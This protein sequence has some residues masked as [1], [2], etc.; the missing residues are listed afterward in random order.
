[1]KRTIANYQIDQ[2]KKA[3]A[4]KEEA[5]SELWRSLGHYD[6]KKLIEQEKI[7]EGSFGCVYRANYDKKRVVVKILQGTK[8]TE[9][10]H[11]GMKTTG[12][13]N[14]EES[15]RMLR[16][17][18]EYEATMLL[19]AETNGVL[20]LI[21]LDI[22]NEVPRMITEYMC[23][24]TLEYEYKLAEAG[25]KESI[26]HPN[27]EHNLIE[28]ANNVTNP[29]LLQMVRIARDVAAAISRI[30]DKGI[31]HLDIAARNILLD[32]KKRP[33]LADFGCAAMEND[34]VEIHDLHKATDDDI[35]IR[36]MKKIDETFDRK[37][38][39]YTHRRPWRWMPH[40]VAV[41][42]PLIDRKVDVYSFGC[43]MFEMAA[44]TV[45]HCTVNDADVAQFKKVKAFNP[46]IPSNLDGRY[47]KIMSNCWEDYDKSPAMSSIAKE[48]VDL[49]SS[50]ATAS[51]SKDIQE[52]SGYWEFQYVKPKEDTI[53]NK[54]NYQSLY[55]SFKPPD[56]IPPVSH[57][58]NITAESGVDNT[59]PLISERINLSFDKVDLSDAPPQIAEYE[60][61]GY[62]KSK[63]S[64]ALYCAY[65]LR[66]HRS[67]ALYMLCIRIED[68]IEQIEMINQCFV[69]LGQLAED[70][71]G[72]TNEDEALD[73]LCWA[74]FAVV[75]EVLNLSMNVA[76]SVR[77]LLISNALSSLGSL[78]SNRTLSEVDI[79]GGNSV[80]GILNLEN[81]ICNLVSF[82]LDNH[83]Q[84]KTIVDTVAQT[85]NSFTGLSQLMINKLHQKGIVAGLLGALQ[86]HEDNVDVSWKLVRALS[87]FPIQQLLNPYAV[88]NDI[89]APASKPSVGKSSPTKSS[90]VGGNKS[91]TTKPSKQ[92]VRIQ[93]VLHDSVFDKLFGIVISCS[94]KLSVEEGPEVDEDYMVLVLKL[95]ETCLNCLFRMCESGV[96]DIDTIN[97]LLHTV[98]LDSITTLVNV[99]RGHSDNFTIQEGAIGLLAHIVNTGF[100]LTIEDNVKSPVHLTPIASGEARI[101]K[102]LELD[103]KLHLLL[104][105]MEKFKVNNHIATGIKSS[106]SEDIKENNNFGANPYHTRSSSRT[107]RT[108]VTLSRMRFTTTTSIVDE[109]VNLQ[110]ATFELDEN[111]E[112]ITAAALQR[113]V[114]IILGIACKRFGKQM[115]DNLLQT[116][117]NEN[118]LSAFNIFS[119]DVALIQFGCHAL[120]WTSRRHTKHQHMLG[121]LFIFRH[122]MSVLQKHRTMWRVVEAV[123]SALLGLMDPADDVSVLSKS[124]ID[125]IYWHMKISPEKGFSTMEE[126]QTFNQECSKELKQQKE[127]FIGY[128]IAQQLTAPAIISLHNDK[129]MIFNFL[130]LFALL[131]AYLQTQED[132]QDLTSQFLRLICCI[133]FWLPEYAK[134]WVDDDIIFVNLSVLGPE[135][136]KMFLEK[137]IIQAITEV[138]KPD[139]PSGAKSK[140]LGEKAD[141]FNKEE[142]NKDLNAIDKFSK[143]LSLSEY[144]F[145]ALEVSRNVIEYP[146][147]LASGLAVITSMFRFTLSDADLVIGNE[148]RDYRNRKSDATKFRDQIRS[149]GIVN[150]CLEA[151]VRQIDHPILIRHSLWIFTMLIS[152]ATDVLN[153]KRRQDQIDSKAIASDLSIHYVPEWAITVAEK[154][155]R[156]YSLQI[157]SFHLLCWMEI[158]GFLKTTFISSLESLRKSAQR[159]LDAPI[160]SYK[161][162]DEEGYDAYLLGQSNKFFGDLHDVSRKMLRHIDHFF[163]RSVG[164]DD[165]F[166]SSHINEKSAQEIKSEDPTTLEFNEDEARDKLMIDTMG[167]SPQFASQ[168]P[169]D[170]EKWSHA[171]TFI[172]FRDIF[173]E[174]DE[175]QQEYREKFRKGSIKGSD[176][177][178]MTEG[179]LISQIGIQLANL[180]SRF[181]EKFKL[182]KVYQ[183]KQLADGVYF[184][185]ERQYA[186]AIRGKSSYDFPLSMSEW[187]PVDVLALLKVPD[188]AVQLDKFL[189]PLALTGID[190]TTLLKIAKESTK[191][192]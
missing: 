10:N 146:N 82:A 28:R 124:V 148:I 104:I 43:V 17:D 134:K 175:E 79:G 162:L 109:N 155:S 179:D 55:A 158:H 11:G 157:L 54:A 86:V 66:D 57:E 137:K 80:E 49:H 14:N 64:S 121:K 183:K 178:L 15:K 25:D 58:P 144:L 136:L 73:W 97:R 190:G 108:S 143:A 125:N 147:V 46:S 165:S 41:A 69:Y 163:P 116:K 166:K 185:L 24:K 151:C 48:L 110:N 115:Q 96:N 159:N 30:H 176:L 140:S 34:M 94:Q 68:N 72:S 9:E 19:K 112:P 70:Q 38:R 168:V 59:V 53:H 103:P 8:E 32:F 40:W 12:P 187:K 127:T 47:A 21:A 4:A 87:W 84:E 141:P 170:V 35:D 78:L 173:R 22:D 93:E 167:V 39:M 154:Y 142:F 160:G 132:C 6:K 74:T 161:A 2:E 42:R 83:K 3:K 102:L 182:L 7:G 31:I 119:T 181:S 105:A 122:L 52:N 135:L 184:D 106:S 65:R 100:V 123:V 45:P 27:N 51:L 156:H 177:L 91:P 186:T 29:V 169:K 130:H 117:F 118:I 99:I 44:K 95:L 33:K 56:N 36:A 120:Y 133:G 171:H 114:A 138:M 81:N 5:H 101:S 77:I 191:V 71:H 13:Q 172:W 128:S 18:L 90:I 1:M 164:L 139:N 153:D 76:K 50:I 111:G 61:I 174:D 89:K 85:I 92:S 149:R 129:L 23:N 145:R 113:S 20:K 60:N 189:R 98:T 16:D 188:H 152:E 75:N 67:I 131:V 150:F 107:S 37:Y 88:I 126:Q 26:F 62:E 63:L 192:R 180:K